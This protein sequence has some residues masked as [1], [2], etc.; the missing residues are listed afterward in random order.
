MATTVIGWGS[1][2][3]LS[4]SRGKIIFVSEVKEIVKYSGSDPIRI[5]LNTLPNY[6]FSFY[7]LGDET[8]LEGIKNLSAG[9]YLIFPAAGLG[10]F[11]RSKSGL[12]CR[13]PFARGVCATEITAN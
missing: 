2:I 1:G 9:H 4:L 6:L 10:H 5:D 7:G 12:E 11:I 13:H 3:F 8:M